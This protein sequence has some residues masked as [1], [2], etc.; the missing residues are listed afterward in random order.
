[1]TMIF[2]IENVSP[3]TTP[4]EK[5]KLAR[6]VLGD[7]LAQYYD[8]ECLPKIAVDV[9]GKPYFPS[10]PD[11]RFSLSHCESAVMAAVDTCD[12]GCDIEDIQ[13]APDSM[14][15]DLAFSSKEIDIISASANPGETLTE[16]WT[17]KEAFVKRLGSIP[18]DPRDWSSDDPSTITRVCRDAGYV[19]SIAVMH[20]AK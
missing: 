13:P 17:R 7:L 16:I 11:I 1:M 3:D 20:E 6:I 12:I 4:A 19:F 15:L 14:L 8:I 5:S 2:K 9:N 10:Y 18:D